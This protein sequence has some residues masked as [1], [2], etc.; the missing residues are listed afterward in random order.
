MSGFKP[1]KEELSKWKKDPVT[2]WI[3]KEIDLIFSDY[4]NAVT[5]G[6]TYH[7]DSIEKTALSTAETIGYLNG[8]DAIKRIEIED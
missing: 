7:Q 8:I 5:K 2:V 4:K 3:F 6:A 1:T